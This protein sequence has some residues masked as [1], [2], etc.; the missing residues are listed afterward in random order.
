MRRSQPFGQEPKCN[1]NIVRRIALNRGN[2]ARLM[3][4]FVNDRGHVVD[5]AAAGKANPLGPI[6]AGD[7]YFD[8]FRNRVQK[9]A[10]FASGRGLLDIDC[11]VQWCS[12]GE[13]STVNI[14]DFDSL[15]VRA[16]EAEVQATVLDA[17]ALKCSRPRGP[18]DRV[19]ERVDLQL[20]NVNLALH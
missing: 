12:V 3:A 5:P 16:F 10:K 7:S 11:D 20:A 8:I 4:T 1:E 2:D 9:I 18:I 19:E 13:T 15:S 14:D 6:P 17:S